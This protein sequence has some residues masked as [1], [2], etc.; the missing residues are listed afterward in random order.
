[1][2]AA[3]LGDGLRA[4]ALAMVGVAAE[5]AH[6]L[7]EIVA[8][9]PQAVPDLAAPDGSTVPEREPSDAIAIAQQAAALAQ[10]EG[11]F[12]FR[13]HVLTNLSSA[14]LQ[15]GEDGVARHAAETAILESRRLGLGGTTAR[16]L[17]RLGYVHLR[18]GDVAGALSSAEE[19]VAAATGSGATGELAATHTVLATLSVLRGDPDGAR[20]H[21]TEAH[22]LFASLGHW[23]PIA[24]M[25]AG[26]ATVYYSIGLLDL[27]REATEH[28]IGT[29]ELIG[30]HP[31]VPVMLVTLVPQVEAAGF[32]DL[33]T[34]L[35]P[36]LPPPPTAP[37]RPAGPR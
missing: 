18:A 20:A 25:W 30:D 32:E 36:Y 3:E 16:A 7:R 12:G 21:A 31:V 1:V 23:V 17:N 27:A 8:A 24:R 9:N 22:D 2:E 10:A 5:Q 4:Q 6:P 28:L 33:L 13:A 34:A 14:A 37:A 15:V 26:G 11:L 19:A 29:L 35:R